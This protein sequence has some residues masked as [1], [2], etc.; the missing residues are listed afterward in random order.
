MRAAMS[1]ARLASIRSGK[2]RQRASSSRK[3]S[4]LVDGPSNT[5]CGRA[6]A[7]IKLAAS[8]G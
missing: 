3:A 5:A 2:A 4:K 6:P 1:N 8:P 7:R